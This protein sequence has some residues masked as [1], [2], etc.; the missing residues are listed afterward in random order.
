MLTTP[1]VGESG[2]EM[3][4]PE[5]SQER[6][7][8]QMVQRCV[9]W[10]HGHPNVQPVYHDNSVYLTY[11]VLPA[12]EARNIAVSAD[13]PLH[14]SDCIE[15]AIYLQLWQPSPFG[16]LMAAD[17]AVAD[18]N[19]VALLRLEVDSGPALLEEVLEDADA[20]PISIVTKPEMA[21]IR[22]LR[23]RHGS[24]T[25]GWAFGEAVAFG[26]VWPHSVYP[27]PISLFGLR[28]QEYADVVVD[29]GLRTG[30]LP[31]PSGP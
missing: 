16:S 28:Q 6:R 30:W 23:D 25:V 15:D 31:D 2:E 3:H 22:S 10:G 9:A 12:G 11:T 24:S 8:E 21:L 26:Q 18:R 17:L 4:Y 5:G 29:H 27:R 13:L 20:L 19:R 14:V 7:L 1:T